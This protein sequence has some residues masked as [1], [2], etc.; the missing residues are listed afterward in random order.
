[1]KDCS[2]F[3]KASALTEGLIFYPFTHFRYIEGVGSAQFVL[4]LDQVAS[5]VNGSA[6]H[7]ASKEWAARQ[8]V[9]QPCATYAG[10]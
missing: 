8:N 10:P 5:S 6:A 3:A 1:M 4:L 7:A 2:D 9:P